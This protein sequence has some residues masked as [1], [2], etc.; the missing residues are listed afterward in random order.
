MNVSNL[1]SDL[2]KRL[3]AIVLSKRTKTETRLR[4]K[5]FKKQMDSERK[6]EGDGFLGSKKLTRR[7]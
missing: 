2:W 4:E 7:V 6:Q 3:S 5:Q 1:K